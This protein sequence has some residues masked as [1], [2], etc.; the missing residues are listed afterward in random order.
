MNAGGGGLLPDPL[1]DLR[2]RIDNLEAR[3]AELEKQND[4]PV[5]QRI[6]RIEEQLEKLEKGNPGPQKHI[7][8]RKG[9]KN[10]PSQII[11]T[12]GNIVLDVCKICGKYEAELVDPCPGK[13]SSKPRSRKCPTCK[14]EY[15]YAKELPCRVCDI[16]EDSMWEPKPDVS[17]R[18]KWEPEYM[19]HLESE[20]EPTREL[21]KLNRQVYPYILQL[22]WL[23]EHYPE[24]NGEWSEKTEYSIRYD[25][26]NK[27]YVASSFRYLLPVTLVYMSLEAARHLR[28]DMNSGKVRF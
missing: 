27:E 7:L 17:R 20:W 16:K 13:P 11:G 19:V 8:F 6:C 5:E 4:C 26:D 9:D 1:Y 10:I 2:R 22:Q 21:E 25:M 14:Y 12:D 24:Q 18:D 28:D 23:F 3:I 15:F